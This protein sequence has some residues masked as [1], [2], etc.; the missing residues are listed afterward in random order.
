VIVEILIGTGVVLATAAAA[1]IALRRREAEEAAAGLG[2]ARSAARSGPRGLKVG[3]VVLTM[4]GE[5][6]LAG[7]LE[8]REEGFVTR[9]FRTPGGPDEDGW[10]AQM[11]PAGDELAQLA[12][13]E[14]VPDG[15]VPEELPIDG[16]R[17]RL[18]QR[19]QGRVERR[20]EQLPKTKA[21]V[22]YTQL[23]DAG[24]K[25]LW[26]LDFEGAPRIALA[27]DRLARHTVD[28]LPGGDL[29]E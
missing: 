18:E 25:I 20:G 10:L 15:A 22:R 9:L 26:V 16:R 29:E 19:G 17:L 4:D 8:L 6:W 14:D 24:G 7:C 21:E 3:D 1:R 11:D 2:E 28:I 13:T 23:G 12:P 27:G 5:L